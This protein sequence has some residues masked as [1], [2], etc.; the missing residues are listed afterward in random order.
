MQVY[1]DKY[2]VTAGRVRAFVEDIMAKNG[3]V[4]N[5]R[6]WLMANPPAYWPASFNFILP[7]SGDG[8][9]ETMP[10]PNLGGTYV[11]PSTNNV[12]LNY[13]FGAARYVYVH[14]EDCYHNTG[15]YGFSTYWYPPAV[16]TGQ[17]GGLARF[18]PLADFPP[19]PPLAIGAKEQLDAK[20]MTCIPAAVLAAFC[21]WDG[22]QLAT[23]EVLDFVTNNGVD[24]G[25]AATCGS[26]CAPLASVQYASDAGSDGTILYRYPFYASTSEGT[27]RIAPPGRVTGDVVRI[28]PGT[29]PWMDVRGNVNEIALNMTGATF[30][31]N[32]SLKYQ[33]IGYSS[34]RAL[35]NPTAL[36]YAEYKA[37]YSGGRC[38]RFKTP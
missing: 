12:G 3:G 21:H 9:V 22:G 19:N 15:T 2:E 36:Q 23:D 17:N 33:G 6:G 13:L 38:M 28:T 31:G 27:F 18:P 24:T 1:L 29:E 7:T 35:Q 32:F 16:M 30:T 11:V 4:P 37:A 25:N 14:G 5:L 10:H 26:R 20:S 8:P 34:A